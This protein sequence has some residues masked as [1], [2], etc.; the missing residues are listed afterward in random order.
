MFGG[1]GDETLSYRLSQIE[2]PIV[3]TISGGTIGQ[4][5]ESKQDSIDLG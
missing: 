4:S 3:P 2:D 1:V 5:G